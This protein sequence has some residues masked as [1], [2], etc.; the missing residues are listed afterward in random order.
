[1]GQPEQRFL[2]LKSLHRRVVLRNSE[3]PTDAP[4]IIVEPGL[5]AARGVCN[6]PS[7][8][9]VL[10]NFL[11]VTLREHEDTLGRGDWRRGVWGQVNQATAIFLGL[12]TSLRGRALPK[13]CRA[14]HSSAARCTTSF[15]SLRLGESKPHTWQERDHVL[16]Q[17]APIH[18]RCN[19]QR[20]PKLLDPFSAHECEPCPNSELHN[21]SSPAWTLLVLCERCLPFQREGHDIPQRKGLAPPQVVER[22]GHCKK[23]KSPRWNLFG[24]ADGARS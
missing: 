1:M 11:C 3:L 14:R 22:R 8:R 6:W 19:T 7:L 15:V 21:H 2:L 9:G 5:P 13:T 18:T 4:A 12:S 23:L 10:F 24:D 20:P 17:H 16:P